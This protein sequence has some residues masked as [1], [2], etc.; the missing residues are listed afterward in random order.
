[1]M[2]GSGLGEQGV[3]CS[4]KGKRCIPSS[5][6]LGLGE[7]QGTGG[8]V[9]GSTIRTSDWAGKGRVQQSKWPTNL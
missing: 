9:F 8:L 2:V 3:L 6:V 4:E 7:L 5:P 1:V